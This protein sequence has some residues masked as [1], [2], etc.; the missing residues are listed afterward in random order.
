[1]KTFSIE[2]ITT[3]ARSGHVVGPALVLNITL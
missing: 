2:V 3:W 1:M